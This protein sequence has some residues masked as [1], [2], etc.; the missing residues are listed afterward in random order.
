MRNPLNGIY[1]SMDI[2]HSVQ[3][4]SLSDINFEAELFGN[5]RHVLLICVAALTPSIVPEVCPGP[6]LVAF[7]S[8]APLS[9]FKSMI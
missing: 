6:S 3:T 5:F 9:P 7:T 8:H 1:G 4:T 2:L